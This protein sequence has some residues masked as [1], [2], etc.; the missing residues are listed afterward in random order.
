MFEIKGE[1]Y[2]AILMFPEGRKTVGDRFLDQSGRQI[3]A[4]DGRPLVWIFAE[5]EA[6]LFARELFD[7][8]KGGRQSIH[9]VYLPWTKEEPR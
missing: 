9:V 8:A 3:A 6:A 4:S 2:A 7:T 1:E 5:E